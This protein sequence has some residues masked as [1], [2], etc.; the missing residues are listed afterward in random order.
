MYEYIGVQRW[1]KVVVDPLLPVYHNAGTRRDNLKLGGNLEKKKLTKKPRKEPFGRP[2]KYE[3]RF[4]KMLMEHMGNGYSYESFAGKIGVTRSTLYEWEKHDNFSDAKKLAVEKNLLFWEKQ[5]IDGLFSEK[6]KS[7]NSTAWIFNL[8]NRFPDDWN[9]RRSVEE[10]NSKIHTVKIE[11][12]EQQTQQIITMSP[13]PKKIE[14]K[15]DKWIDA[16]LINLHCCVR[17]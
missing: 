7:L 13:D 3:I 5:G 4:C 14:S 10:D 15:N 6:G 9:D 11:L 12:P 16:S 17:D 2:T 8:K 1:Q